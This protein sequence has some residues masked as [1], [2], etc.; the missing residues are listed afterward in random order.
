VGLARPLL[1]QTG[2]G[3]CA[4]VLVRCGAVNRQTRADRFDSAATASRLE[5]E[6]PGVKGRG[7]QAHITVTTRS[8]DTVTVTS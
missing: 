1:D 2:P 4:L 5:R 6:R 8:L 3:F 7:R